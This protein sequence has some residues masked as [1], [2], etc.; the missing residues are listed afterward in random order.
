MPYSFTYFKEE[1]KEWFL[2]NVPTSKRI[3]D[4]GPGIGTYSD[5]LRSSGYRIDAVEIY[6]P[7]VAKY[8]LRDKYDNVFIGSIVTFDIND[9]DFIILGDVLE[10]IPTNYAK[11][12]IRDIVAAK[13]ECLVAIPYE[14]EQ[15]EHEGN[16]HETHYQPDLTHEVMA[17][18][19]PDLSCIYRNEYYGYYTYV[20]TKEEKMYVLYASSS[21]YDVVCMAVESIKKVSDIPVIVYMLDD[22]KEVPGAYT[23][24]WQCGIEDLPKNTY[25]DRNNSK[26]YDI[27]IQRPLIV[28]DALERFAK[29]V[30]YVDSDSVAT[31]HVDDIFG[32]Y[33]EQSC[34][35]YFTEGIYDYLFI[36]GRG[37]TELSKTLERP[38]CELFGVDQSVRK[39][40]RQTGYFVAGQNT[41][42]FLNEWSWMCNHPEVLKN[43][44]YYAPYHEETIVNVLLWKHKFL[45]GLPYI[46]VNASLDKLDR[47]YNEDNWGKYLESWFKLPATEDQLFFLHGE[48]D[49]VVMSKIMSKLPSKMSNPLRVLFLAPHLSTGG[50]PQFLLK[51]IQALKDSTDV[52]IFVVEY[53]C[54]SLDFVVQRDQIMDIV[55]VHTLYEDK[56]ELFTVI[57][58]F[59]PDV[60]H[61]DEM[62]ERLD[63]EMIVSLYNHNRSYRIIETCHDVSFVPET[64]IFIPDAFAFCSPYHLDTFASV[65]GYK[66]VIEYPI[67]FNFM[68]WNEKIGAQSNLG[69]DLTKKHVVNIGLWTKGK[70]QGEGLEVAKQLS[71]V[72]FHFVGNQ[73]GNF[74]DYWEPLME[75]IPENVTVWGERIDTHTFMKAADVFMFN[76]TWEC[77][78]LVIREAISYGKSILARN[79]PQ[80]KDMFTNYITDLDPTMIA[81]QI[82]SLLETPANYPIP[83]N[84]TSLNFANAN[85]ELYKH[86]VSTIPHKN[87]I[88]DWNITQHFVGQP[89]LE[90]TGTSTSDFRVEFYDGPTLIYHDNLKCN[91]WVKLAREY[92]TQWRT[93]VYKDGEKV[94]DK[95]LDLEGKRVYISFDSSSLGDTI[96]WMPYVEEFRCV[97][98]CE[99]IVSTF[100]NFLFEKEYPMLEFVTPGTAVNNI[101][102]MYKLGWF[103][104]ENK[105]PVLP[106]TIPLQQTATN[107]LGLPYKEIKP[108]I[109]SMNPGF[110]NEKL[111]TI[112][113][114]STA[115]CKFW[116]RENW[117]ELINYLHNNGY[118]IVN[119]S[120]EDNPFDSCQGLLDKSM[121]STIERIEQ[122][123]FFIGLSSGLSWLAWALNK[124]VI[125]IS[126][127]TDANHEFQCHRPVNTN[128]CHGC[129]NDPQYTFDKGDWDW[130]PVHKG[131]ERQFEC[132]KSVTPRMVI[133]EIKK[134]LN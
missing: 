61:I 19:Y 54:H 92:Y 72:H 49:P 30:C 93:V 70:N 80:Y 118:E 66:Q 97:H 88:K 9:Y 43:P 123:A 86:A 15:G 1:V 103:Y 34:Y 111:V 100:K 105:E 57:D 60:I 44:Q 46:Y 128:V 4:V 37:S 26:I 47:I 5:L 67:E 18:R 45:D 11:E 59:K 85:L 99:V 32:Y 10:H 38:A 127:F 29:I 125:M 96:A 79:L 89:F 130:C 8:N 23:V 7:Y 98:N 41:I 22:Y 131:T 50:M 51:R 53:Q 68:G 2:E 31:A 13:K 122:S 28:K 84:N 114:N 73:A 78:P 76:S 65:D 69:M 17:E 91:H 101:Y 90:I 6:E 112:A 75:N 12:L 77:N 108:R 42:P 40:Y 129:W 82:R 95:L 55:P 56:M 16:I 58:H 74:I 24:W 119:V 63:R 39:E 110:V 107:I 106:N 48:K 126:N 134:L 87:N 64:K 133:D 52:E 33:D 94:Y 120:L 121:N 116:T 83:T 71:D 27:L 115:G 102:A 21:Y 14:M 124:E 36:N 117:Q 109:L 20:H 104:N 132:Q 62:S 25:I 35:P 81:S 113:T 3:L